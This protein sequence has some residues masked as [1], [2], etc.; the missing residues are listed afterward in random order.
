MDEIRICQSISKDCQ[1]FYDSF[2]EICVGCNCCGRLDPN[3]MWDS[4]Y[5]LAIIRL[6]DLVEHLK[7]E[8]CQSNLQQTNICSSISYWNEKLKEIIAHI[9]FDKKGETDDKN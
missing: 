7:S 5:Y 6:Q 3:S 9:D 8:H 1:N 4:R 2:G